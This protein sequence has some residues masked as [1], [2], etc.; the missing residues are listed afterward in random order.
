M[1]G[2][3]QENMMTEECMIQYSMLI[4]VGYFLLTAFIF[5]ALGYYMGC[6]AMK[7]AFLAQKNFNPKSEK[8][9]IYSGSQP[10]ESEIMRCL[11]PK[12]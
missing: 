6:K 4:T 2:E 7:D 10:E 5:G 8:I 11:R 12:D 3:R 9:K 1:N